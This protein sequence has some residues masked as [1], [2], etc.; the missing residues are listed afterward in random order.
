MLETDYETYTSVYSCVDFLGLGYSDQAWVLGRGVLS[1]EELNLALSAYT[2]W[3]IDIDAF[4]YTPQTDC[5]AL[6]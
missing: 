1:E 5:S 6:P 4:L 3:G 2:R